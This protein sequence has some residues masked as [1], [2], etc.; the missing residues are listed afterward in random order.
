[1]NRRL[2]WRTA[3]IV[4]LSTASAAAQGS[5]DKKEWQ[6]WSANDC[7]KVLQ[8]S[9]WAYRWSQSD[10]QMAFGRSGKLGVMGNTNGVTVGDDTKLEI[11]YVVQLRSSQPIREAM[12]RQQQIQANYDSM[13][14]KRRASIDQQAEKILNQKYDD[15]VVVR[16]YYGSNIPLYERDLA[17]FWQTTYANGM[18]PQDA[19][20]ITASGKK[21]SPLGMVS[22]NSNAD[23]FEL[24]F[25]RLVDGE[26]VVSATSKVL[27]IEFQ[28]PAIQSAKA[29]RVLVDFK[30]EK[31]QYH[32]TL[33]Y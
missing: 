23:I 11:W 5:W 7:K 10:P 22:S 31:M 27:S 30:P 21:V 18:V 24:V 19:F 32:G 20:L 6:K 26:P 15:R 4:L 9:P 1:M 2:V 17:H 25:P 28:S 29:A 8:D 12:V 3:A 16:V 13:D 33:S 14:E